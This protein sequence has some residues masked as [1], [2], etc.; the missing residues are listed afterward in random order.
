MLR[1]PPTLL[2][3]MHC[4]L[5]LELLLTGSRLGVQTLDGIN[6]LPI[7]NSRL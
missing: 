6:Y 1:R 2:D 5:P 7:L 4:D 3:V